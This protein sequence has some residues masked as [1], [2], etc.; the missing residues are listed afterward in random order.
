MWAATPCGS[1]AGRN[2]LLGR[3][4]IRGFGTPRP[5]IPR[6][7]LQ[8]VQS[9][10]LQYA[11]SGRLRG[12][13][14]GTLADCGS[15]HFDRDHIASGPVRA[16]V[17]VVKIENQA[18]RPPTPG[19]ALAGVRPRNQELQTNFQAACYAPSRNSTLPSGAS[20]HAGFQATSHANPSGSA[21]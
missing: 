6:G 11:E 21:K 7:D 20:R 12:R 15:D 16:E 1:L 4:K 9:H 2:R 14:R 3:E 5:A 13:N 19:S 10:Q 8:R 18:R 17:L